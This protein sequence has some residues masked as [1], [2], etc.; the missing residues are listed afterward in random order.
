MKTSRD[1]YV[2][3]FVALQRTKRHL[4][5]AENQWR[6]WLK[7]TTLARDLGQEDWAVLARRHALRSAE[8]A[9]ALHQTLVR[10][11]EEL[12]RLAT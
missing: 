6:L 7:R 10:Q 3:T 8:L 2:E 12:R 5:R 4:E 9:V 11:N 1:V